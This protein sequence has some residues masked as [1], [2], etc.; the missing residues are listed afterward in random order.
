M[1]DYFPWLYPETARKIYETS[2]KLTLASS[3]ASYTAEAQ[4]LDILEGRQAWKEIDSS[5]LYQY[6]LVKQ[7]IVEL[8]E[9]DAWEILSLLRSCLVRN[10]ANIDNPLLYSQTHAGTKHLIEH[11]QLTIKRALERA[12]RN[13]LKDDDRP[14][15]IKLLKE[16]SEIRQI[17]GRTALYLSGGAALGFLQLGVVKALR[18]EGLIPK[19]V[20]GSSCGSIAASLYFKIFAEEDFDEKARE[21]IARGILETTGET[22]RWWPKFKRLARQGTLLD[23]EHV[24]G[25]LWDLLGEETFIESFH[26]TG[27]VFN[28][29]VFSEN[30]LEMPIVLNYVTAPDVVIAS[31]ICASIAYPHVLPPRSVLKKSDGQLI[32]WHG[33]K[34]GLWI[35]GSIVADIPMQRLAEL[36]NVTNNVVVNVNPHKNPFMRLANFLTAG[37]FPGHRL[38]ALLLRLGK[39]EY[40]HWLGASWLPAPLKGLLGVFDQPCMGDVLILPPV[41]WYLLRGIVSDPEPHVVDRADREGR[42]ATYNG[43][44]L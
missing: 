18:E 7:T 26:R 6:D 32:P 23:G 10:F 36:F 42:L 24:S 4:K 1:L 44:L 22:G 41:S 28:V 39:M 37:W 8:E 30:K 29:T 20:C 31:A 27:H 43:N 17:M 19:V 14:N 16:L 34:V 38:F 33:E 11:F 13:S 12:I 2:Q 3:Y 21:F 9:A 25:K 40:Y 15:K 35:D 5:S